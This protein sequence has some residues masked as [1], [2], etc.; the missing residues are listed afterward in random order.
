MLWKLISS[1]GGC[2]QTLLFRAMLVACSQV[3]SDDAFSSSD[4]YWVLFGWVLASISCRI[5][6]V[7]SDQQGNL[8]LYAV[9]NKMTVALQLLLC[10]RMQ[11]MSVSQLDSCGKG[12]LVNAM[13]TDADGCASCVQLLFFVYGVPLRAFG[14]VT[15]LALQTGAIATTI[16]VAFIVLSVFGTAK[17][18]SYMAFEYAEKQ[19]Q[20][21][22][23]IALI[24]HIIEKIK[25]L[26][27]K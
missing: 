12:S 21:D 9:Q 7:V 10:Q 13:A 23:R 17:F 24:T 19:A 18:S 27:L 15:L 22:A 26:K 2:A 3:Y 20:S 14:L 8:L 1:V 25:H 6:T 16:S 11:K 4:R 5:V